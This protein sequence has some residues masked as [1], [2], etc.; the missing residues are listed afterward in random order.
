MKNSLKMK[1][2]HS[3]R[4][5][6]SRTRYNTINNNLK[7]QDFFTRHPLPFKDIYKRRYNCLIRSKFSYKNNAEIQSRSRRIYAK[8]KAYKEKDY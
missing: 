6:L 3:N 5:V 8:F 7:L 2:P 4:L 1:S